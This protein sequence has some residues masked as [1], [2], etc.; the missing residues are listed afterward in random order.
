[1]AK[2]KINNIK[3][4]NKDSKIEGTF[5]I[6]AAFIVL[7]TAMMNSII[8]SAIASIFLMLYGFYKLM[9]RK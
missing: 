4:N 7:F 8:S 3:E 1:M 6:I 2:K 9:R 5:L